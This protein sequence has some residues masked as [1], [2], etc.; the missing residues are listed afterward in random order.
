M[1]EIA[2]RT[3]LITGFP[4]ETEADF[5]ELYDWVAETRFD[6]LGVFPY[7]H[8]E[9]THAYSKED[10]VPEE[11]KQERAEA[12][13][14]LQSGISLELNQARVGKTYKVLID[15]VEN[16]TYIGRTEQDSPE[17]DNEV[18]IPVTKDNHLRVGDFVYAT[19]EKAD[20]YDLYATVAKEEPAV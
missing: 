14:E 1:P 4:G 15:R 9:N 8:E 7:S 13:M 2:L 6:R 18:I 11:V 5:Q 20:Y 17:V 10:D 16:G 3:T 12:I 19:V